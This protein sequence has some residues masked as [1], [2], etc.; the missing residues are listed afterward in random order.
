MHLF[1]ILPL[2]AFWGATISLFVMAL[3]YEGL[4]CF[5]N[6]L[7]RQIITNQLVLKTST[8]P[9][10]TRKASFH[11]AIEKG[12]RSFLHAFSYFFSQILMMVFML[13]NGYFCLALVLGRFFG[14]LIFATI[15][16]PKD[17][18]NSSQSCCG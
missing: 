16:L 3:L 13:F 1:I 6:R 11:S 12:L 14:Y 9:R 18:D 2:I 17:T 8:I 4:V 10:S 7:E 5:R 15:L